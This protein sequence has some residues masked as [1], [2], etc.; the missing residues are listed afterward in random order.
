MVA[1]SGY[2]SQA[3]VERAKAAGFDDH[4]TKPATPVQIAETFLRHDRLSR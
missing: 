2:A 4:L 3:D 1:V